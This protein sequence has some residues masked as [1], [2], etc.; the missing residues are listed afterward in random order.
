MRRFDTIQDSSL[1]EKIIDII[2]TILLWPIFYPLTKWGGKFT[3]NIFHG[4]WGYIPL[5]LNSFIWALVIYWGLEKIKN[6]KHITTS[7]SRPS[8]PPNGVGSGG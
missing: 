1:G 4:L 5:I 6:K 2:S 8:P 7:S 3:H